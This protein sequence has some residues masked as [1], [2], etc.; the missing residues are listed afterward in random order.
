MLSRVCP[1]VQISVRGQKHVHRASRQR[2]GGFSHNAR[3]L[4]LILMSFG[5]SFLTSASSLSPNPAR[6][7][8]GGGRGGRDGGREVDNGLIC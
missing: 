2:V 6:K 4:T 7:G 3:A 1:V 5:V 8:G